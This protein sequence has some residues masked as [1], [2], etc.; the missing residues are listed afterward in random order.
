M[1]NIFAILLQV[2]AMMVSP[3]SAQSPSAVVEEVGAGVAGVQFMDYVE[4]GQVIRLGAVDRLVLGYLK[5][6]WRETITGGTVTVGTEQSQV[7]GGEVARVQVQCEGGKMMLSAELAGK[8]G[9]MAAQAI[10]HLRSKR[11]AKNIPINGPIGAA[12]AMM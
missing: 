10:C 1:S 7:A 4:P 8:S 12:M 5:S 9:A 11:S 2:V 6:C 3:A